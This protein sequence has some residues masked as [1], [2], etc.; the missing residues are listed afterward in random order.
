MVRC[1]ISYLEKGERYEPL[2]IGSLSEVAML[3]IER[4]EKLGIW[5]INWELIVFLL[6]QQ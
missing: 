3:L 1:T 5:C 6:V 2:K 4:V